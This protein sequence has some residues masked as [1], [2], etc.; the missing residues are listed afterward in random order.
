MTRR[1]FLAVAATARE[2][3]IESLLNASSL[4]YVLLRAGASSVVGLRWRDAERPAPL[5]SLVKPFLALAYGS[6][7]GWEFPQLDC[8][9]CWLPRGHGRL[10]VR[11][12][13]AQSCNSY[14]LRIASMTA[15]EDVERVAGCYGLTM[16]GDTSA[17][18]LIG[19]R[20]GWR[21][22]P[23]QTALAYNELAQRRGEPGV[24]LIF[25]A[26]RQCA[27]MGTASGIGAGAAAKT[28]TAPCVHADRA[29]GD[30][31]VAT[32]LPGYVLVARA[33]GVPGAECAR[34]AG[35]IVRAVMR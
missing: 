8:S 33:H 13:L 29:P 24:T 23:L 9:G 12:A 32:I 28:G 35:A 4:E 25:D 11:R 15:R 1:D 17:E 21:A 30:G 20:A 18:A 7:H 10:D 31:L 3:S 27:E 6:S 34:R 19:G 22:T 5:G 2:Y 14:F 16:P 26:L